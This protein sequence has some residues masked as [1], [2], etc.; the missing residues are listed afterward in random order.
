VWAS[1]LA[2]AYS[3]ESIPAL[4]R[5]C[6]YLNEWDKASSE[7]ARD[8]SGF[9]DVRYLAKLESA[10]RDLEKS[11][12]LDPLSRLRLGLSVGGEQSAVDALKEPQPPQEVSVD[13]LSQS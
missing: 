2:E 12:G 11:F 8:G 4:E 1:P 5:W 6:C 13:G 10:L 9:G 7:I 3:E